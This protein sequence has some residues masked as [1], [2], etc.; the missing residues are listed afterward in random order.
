MRRG[1]GRGRVSEKYKEEKIR[2][3]TLS[4]E[5]L[6]EEKIEFNEI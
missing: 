6:Q 5:N 1:I 4:R 2:K 3:R